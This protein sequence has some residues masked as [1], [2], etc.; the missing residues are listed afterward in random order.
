MYHYVR[1]LKN[2]TYPEIKGLEIIG[3]KNQLNY[4]KE[5]FEF[6][7][8]TEIINSLYS[9]TET[10]NKI[11]LTFDDGLKDHYTNVF[12]IL[13]K[14]NIAGYF[15][16]P[17]KPIEENLVLDVHKIHFILA[18]TNVNDIIKEIFLLIRENTTLY[19]LKT[20]QEYF[21]NLA[22]ANRFDTKEIIFIKRILQR[23]LPLEL[24]T[25]ITSNLFKKFVTCNEQDFSKNLYMSID[26]MKEMVESGMVFGSHSYSHQWLSNVSHENLINEIE[27]SKNFCHK[28]DNNNNELIMCYPYGDY[29]D[30]VIKEISKRGFK[31]GLTTNVGD[32]EITRESIF[33]LNRFDTNDFPQ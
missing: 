9:N 12:P 11:I 24:R 20:T 18:S 6:G 2:S 1:S 8:F 19:N 30:I 4:F 17:S 31:I 5:N 13:K 10:K 3:F 32:A 27:K 33:K 26:E 28:I 16:P 25:K 29:N 23:E 21:D 15:F 14:M 7:D 22:V